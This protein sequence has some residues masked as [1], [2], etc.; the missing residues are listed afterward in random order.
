MS[1]HVNE[2]RLDGAEDAHAR[3]RPAG[4]AANLVGNRR[5][6]QVNVIAGRDAQLGV[7]L[8]DLRERVGQFCA[9]LLGHRG[10]HAGVIHRQ[11]AHRIS[12]QRRNCAKRLR[13]L[14]LFERRE[15]DAQSLKQRFRGLEIGRR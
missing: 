10:L 9:I 13:A 14:D 7:L 12:V 6:E 3:A 4:A 8:G 2:P 5:L 11:R 1:I 15:R